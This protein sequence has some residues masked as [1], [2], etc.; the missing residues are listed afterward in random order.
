MSESTHRETDREREA[1]LRR[2]A[3]VATVL[4]APFW[5]P[6]GIAAGLMDSCCQRGAQ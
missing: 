4:L 5:V 2:Y 3:F 1:R 6:A